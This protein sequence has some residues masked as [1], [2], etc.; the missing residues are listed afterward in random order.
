MRFAAVAF[1]N[2]TVDATTSVDPNVAAPVTPNDELNDPVV[3]DIAARLVAP[4]T[5]RV[6]GMGIPL[7]SARKTF[8]VPRALQAEI[9]KAS[10]SELS[11]PTPQ[12]VTPETVYRV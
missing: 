4:V 12:S 11:R 1:V 5:R 2:C 3:A 8:P 9:T 6:P 10:P 7:E